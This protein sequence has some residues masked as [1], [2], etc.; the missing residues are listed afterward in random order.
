MRKLQFMFFL[1]F[2]T[3][4][5]PAKEYHVSKS[6]NDSNSGTKDSPLLTIQAAS[7]IAQPGDMITVHEGVY[8]ERV[9]PARGGISDE[10]RI[11]YQAAKGENVVIKGSEMI[12]GWVKLK[13]DVWKVTLPNDFFGDFNPY[14]DVIGGE[15]YSTPKDGYDRHTGAVYLNGHWLT[16]AKDLNACTASGR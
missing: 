13:K 2:C 3:V 6:G 10:K 15:W 16:E 7:D 5:L 4:S 1:Q 9:N 11:V 14:S 12:K 8:R